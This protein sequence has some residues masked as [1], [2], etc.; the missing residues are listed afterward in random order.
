M[1]FTFK[2]G[3]NI[4]NQPYPSEMN[5]RNYVSLTLLNRIHLNLEIK[6]NSHIEGLL[7]LQWHCNTYALKTSS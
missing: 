4:G 3:Q 6:K 5:M 1:E 7:H 2:H